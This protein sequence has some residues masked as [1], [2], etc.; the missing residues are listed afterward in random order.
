MAGINRQHA[1]KGD[2]RAVGPTRVQCRAP[3]RVIE[4]DLADV[5][6]LL[7]RKERV[8]LGVP[9]GLGKR[10]RAR[11]QVPDLGL[12]GDATRPSHDGSGDKDGK[13]QSKQ[14]AHVCLLDLGASGWLVPHTSR[15][16]GRAE[17]LL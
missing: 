7:R 10:T 2:G 13:Q 16:D 9:P 4:I 11:Q 14:S 3:E 12:R 8:G 6:V 17:E 1:R 15:A 5:R